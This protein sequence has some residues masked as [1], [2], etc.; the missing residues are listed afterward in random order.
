MWR[1]GH[2]SWYAAGLC[3]LTI[4]S[5]FSYQSAVRSVEA[6]TYQDILG[7]G[8]ALFMFALIAWWCVYR[9]NEVL[10]CPSHRDWQR[11]IEHHIGMY[12]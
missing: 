5:Y 1:V 9:L 8:V 7:D 11:R 2:M 12:L 10:H 4:M 3:L 6:G